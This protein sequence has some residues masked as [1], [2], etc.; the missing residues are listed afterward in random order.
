MSK[1]YLLED[2]IVAAAR[3]HN[4][5]VRFLEEEIRDLMWFDIAMCPNCDTICL[6]WTDEPI[7]Y[8]IWTHSCPNCKWEYAQND[9]IPLFI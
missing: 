5:R 9:Y 4:Q 1:K 3:T 7:N 2:S 8:D 6:L